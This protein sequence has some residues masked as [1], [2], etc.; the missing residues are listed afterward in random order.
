LK[1]LLKYSILLITLSILVIS[2]A[3]LINNLFSAGFRTRE[4]AIVAAVFMTIIF[5]SLTIFFRGQSK[6]ADSKVMHSLVSVSLKFLMELVFIF[7]WF[8]I[9]KKSGL[10]SVILFFVLYLAYS[11][12]LTF[13][14][15][16]TLKHSPL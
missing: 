5:I 3:F 4:V 9:A 6:E 1:P 11:L 13:V 7:F 14:I 10:S 2:A 12:F 15:L 16:K 8:F